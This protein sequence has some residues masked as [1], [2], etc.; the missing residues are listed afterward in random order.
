MTLNRRRLTASRP[1]KPM[2]SRYPC[3][4][5]G[6]RQIAGVPGK[7]PA[8]GAWIYC[9][10]YRRCA[11]GYE[12]AGAVGGHPCH[13]H[14]RTIHGLSFSF[15]G[16]SRSLPIA[17]ARAASRSPK[18]LRARSTFANLKRNAS[19]FAMAV[20]TIACKLTSTCLSVM[21]K[22]ASQYPSFLLI[23]LFDQ[24]HRASFRPLMN[25]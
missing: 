21:E 16:A 13:R 6:A 20:Y 11:G 10:P 17:S 25:G 5:R 19:K 1:A 14:G 23:I 8:H 15:R 3:R 12:C 22:P 24:G 9:R 4:I 18:K 7:E 2:S